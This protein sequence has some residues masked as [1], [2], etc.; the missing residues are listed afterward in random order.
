[1]LLKEQVVEVVNQDR[2]FPPP[3]P[4][5]LDVSFGSGSDSKIHRKPDSLIKGVQVLKS[6]SASSFLLDLSKDF[7][8][9]PGSRQKALPRKSGVATGVKS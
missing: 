6:H 1:M 7:H 9:R 2:F 3:T 5:S 8:V 4:K